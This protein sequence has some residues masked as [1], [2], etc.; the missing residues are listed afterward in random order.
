MKFFIH[1]QSGH[2]TEGMTETGG[3]L[4]GPLRLPSVFTHPLHAVTRGFADTSILAHIGNSNIHLTSSNRSFLS[5]ITVTSTELNRVSGVT[6]NIQNS[7]NN[8]LN[9]SGV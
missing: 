6:N 4:S 3:I 7:L 8:I 2:I 5:G 9:R 1:R